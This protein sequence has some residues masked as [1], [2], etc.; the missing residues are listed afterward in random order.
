MIANDVLLRKHDSLFSLQGYACSQ[1]LVIQHSFK[2]GYILSCH[3]S[4]IHYI[5]SDITRDVE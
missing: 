4:D 1:Y 2:L 5:T 3:I